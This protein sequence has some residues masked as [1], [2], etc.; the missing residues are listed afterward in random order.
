MLWRCPKE[1]NH[2]PLVASVSAPQTSHL[3]HP[4]QPLILRAPRLPAEWSYWWQSPPQSL[5]PGSPSPVDPAEAPGPPGG[6]QLEGQNWG[7]LDALAPGID[8]GWGCFPSCRPGQ[9]EGA[10]LAAP[11]LSGPGAVGGERLIPCEPLSPPHRRRRCRRRSAPGECPSP[12]TWSPPRRPPRIPGL[13]AAPEN[14]NRRSLLPRAKE[15]MS[16]SDED[17]DPLPLTPWPSCESPSSYT[18]TSSLFVYLLWS[19]G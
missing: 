9:A 15:G 18:L 12:A 17:P 4:L 8:S 3:S 7:H 16:S 11:R 14:P 13:Y 2:P 10:G 1:R 19:Q 5:L 6:A